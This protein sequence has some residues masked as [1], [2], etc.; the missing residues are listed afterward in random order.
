MRRRFLSLALALAL[1]LALVPTAFP[2]SA[3]AFTPITGWEMMEKLGVGINIGNTLEARSWPEDDWSLDN[4]MHSEF[5]WGEARIEQW[6]FKAIAQKGFAGVRI[7]ISWEPHMDDDYNID[8]EWMERVREVV[9]WALAAGLIVTINTHHES[10]FYDLMH[11][12][13]YDQA[14]EWLMAVWTQV[15][16]RFKEYPETLIFEPMNEPRPGA[17]GWHWD[18]DLFAKEIPILS[19]TSNRLSH[20]A[21][22]LIRNSGGYND[23]RVVALTIQ[24]ADPNLLYL[25]EHPDD[26]YAMV[27]VFFYPSDRWEENALSQI[28]AALDKKIPVVIKEI[29]PIFEP[30]DEARLVEWG[31]YA[32]GELAKLG[33]PTQYWN[34]GGS[35]EIFN[36]HT[37]EWPRKPLLEAIFTAHGLTPG[38][39]YVL[40]SPFPY[41]L[42]GPFEDSAFTYWQSG[43]WHLPFPPRILEE[44]EKMVV[45]YEGTFT[46]GYA[47]VR[48]SP[49]PRAQLTTATR[50]SPKNPASSPLTCVGWKE[51]SSASPRG[52]RETPPKSSASTSTHGRERDLRSPSPPPTSPTPPA[53]HTRT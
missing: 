22:A 6:H 10:G 45:E 35:F 34:H 1:T 13:T 11:T 18:Y 41:E 29:A 26:P 12:G 28:K 39:D 44:A 42:K 2:A 21:L 3:A 43:S 48:H 16:E 37:G 27:G 33:V 20:D 30:S 17:T 23:K 47:F 25:Y 51:P 24:Q 19:E 9:D 5:V 38:P 52:A 50:A 40:P 31:A 7:P 4:H 32:Y 49:S 53:G 46:G 36:R 8:E 14:K 15:A